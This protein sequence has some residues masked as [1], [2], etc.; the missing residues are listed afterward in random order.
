VLA[1]RKAVSDVRLSL[2][3][4]G[5]VPFELSVLAATLRHAAVLGCYI[6]G[7]P[8]FG[9]ISAIETYARCSALGD[10]THTKIR[11]LLDYKLWSEGRLAFP[12]HDMVEQNAADLCDAVDILINR[13]EGDARWR[14]YIAA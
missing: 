14:G 8:N 2:L 9:R 10:W 5:C 13:V 6:I 11:A 7:N 4:A 1:Y 3:S 12:E